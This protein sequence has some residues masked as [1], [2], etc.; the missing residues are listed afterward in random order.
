MPT[1]V[2]DMQKPAEAAQARNWKI[3]KQLRQVFSR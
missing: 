2:L 1:C 3:V